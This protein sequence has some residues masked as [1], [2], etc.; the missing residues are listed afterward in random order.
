MLLWSFAWKPNSVSTLP[1]SPSPGGLCSKFRLSLKTQDTATT[2]PTHVQVSLPSSTRTLTWTSLHLLKPSQSFP[3]T[4]FNVSHGMMKNLTIKLHPHLPTQKALSLTAK[5]PV[6]AFTLST[7]YPN[8]QHSLP[9]TV[10]ILLSDLLKKF[11]VSIS[12]AFLSLCMNLTTLQPGSK[13]S[14]P[15]CMN[16]LCHRLLQLSICMTLRKV[17]CQ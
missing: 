2:T 5:Q 10:L 8:T 15:L 4:R 6:A 14:D 1:V 13:T 17:H 16:P 9:T 11:T 3:A 7:R 12:L